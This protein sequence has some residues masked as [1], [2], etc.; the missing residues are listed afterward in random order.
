MW[1]SS[2]FHNQNL[3]VFLE[4]ARQGHE[5]VVDN[6]IQAGANL[7]GADFD[8]GFATLAV[9]T[10]LRI[11]DHVALQIWAKAGMRIPSRQETR[12]E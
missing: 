2:L 11:G 10:A 9:Q 5:I 12:D 7:G 6:L 1:L 8:G 3:V 4:A